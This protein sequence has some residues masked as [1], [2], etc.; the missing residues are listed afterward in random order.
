MKAV[1]GELFPSYNAVEARRESEMEMIREKLAQNENVD[2]PVCK[3]E[4]VSA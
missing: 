2:T 4:R 1:T 3:V